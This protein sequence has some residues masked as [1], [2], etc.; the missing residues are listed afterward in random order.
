MLVSLFA[1]PASPATLAPD[2]AV[3][4]E[5]HVA[6]GDASATALAREPVTTARLRDAYGVEHVVRIVGGPNRFGGQTRIAGR[7]VPIV[8]NVVRLD[9]ADEGPR[10]DA[11]TRGDPPATWAASSLPVAFAMG[12]PLSRDLGDA[13]LAE[14]DVALRTWPLVACTAWRT[15]FAETTSAPP[16]DDGIDAIYWHDDA[17]PAALVPGALAQTILHTDAT[18][19]LRDADIHV[20]GAEYRWSLDGAGATV[21]ARGV[22]VH[23][24]GHA[25]GLGHSTDPRATMYATHADG[26]AW[27]S[28]E[29]DDRDGVCALYPG[30]SGADGCET[31]ASCP[32]GFACVAKYC[33]RRGTRGETC[34]PCAR[35]PGACEGSGDDAR[36]VDLVASAGGA[37]LGK[38]CGRACVANDDCGPRFR[39]VPTTASGDLQCVSNDGC[40][41]G[42]DACT[43]DAECGE[44]RC[45]HGACVGEPDVASPDGG[46]ADASGADSSSD[47]P[48][49]RITSSGGCA[50]SRARA[51]IAARDATPLAISFAWVL[52][53]LRRR[54]RLGGL[55]R[56]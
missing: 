42:P 34:A 41:S 35:V 40:A 3:V 36:C 19:A 11:W 53:L 46:L 7:V 29:A 18:G 56:R 26:I 32:A 24:L 31:G 23:E 25:L 28:L 43:S 8:G 1:S 10:A 52:L 49:D 12:T 6:Y 22:L 5:A 15:R 16:G 44:A 51:S 47:A 27:R 21:D 37:P 33:E 9:L 30:T 4:V 55:R 45:V 17:W 2:Q 50:T 54:L 39:C 13:S 14:L 48:P 38:V 20:N